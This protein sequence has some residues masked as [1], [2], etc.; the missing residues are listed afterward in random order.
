MGLWDA[1]STLRG[2]CAL[3]MLIAAACGGGGSE[4]DG[5]PAAADPGSS[6]G[7]ASSSSGGASS[8]G[9]SSGGSS[10]GSGADAGA[11]AGPRAPVKLVAVTFNTGTTDGLP[12][13]D[14]PN[15]GYTSTQA[16]LSNDHY[17]D[18]LAWKA[19]VDD[20]KAFFAQVKPD[21]VM[22]QEIFHSPECVNV[23]QNAR[24]G[25]VCETWQT[26]DPTVT[27]VVLGAGYQIACNV[28]KTDKCAAVKTSFGSFRGC[29]G[30]VCLDGLAGARVQDCGGG[31]RVGRGVIDLVGGG[32][33][34]VV[35]AHGS[36]GYKPADQDCRSKQFKQVFENLDGAP[37]A[38]GARNI[39]MGDLNTDPGRLTLVDGSARTF[40]DYVG[41]NKKFRFVTEVGSSAPATYLQT[42]V[43]GLGGGFNIDHVVSDAFEGSCWAAGV[44]A[45]HPNVTQMTYFDHRPIVCSLTEKTK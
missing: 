24:A 21:L 2:T 13:D 41:G 45:G 28:G 6:S 12:H 44:T 43:P 15:D 7:A 5:T 16:K 8:G 29:T 19:A 25:F 17:G 3:Y 14:P 26:G 36:S 37:A 22:F 18:G 11:D 42:L 40:N 33:I 39:V 34:T 35:L 20:A 9:S 32:S 38:N 1:R 10:S 30:A 4:G 27:Q 23:P 31:S